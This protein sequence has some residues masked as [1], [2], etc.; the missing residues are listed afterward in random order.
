ML[1]PPQKRLYDLGYYERNRA[2]ILARKRERHLTD[3]RKSMLNG[4]R[5]RAR[6]LG[7]PFDLTEQDLSVPERCPVL[8]IPIFVRGGEG[9]QDHSP[10][11]DRVMPELGYVRG[12][13][14]VISQRANRIKNDASP[15]E[16]EAVAS[17][18]RDT[19]CHGV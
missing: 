2:A 5:K 18:L 1:R 8:G 7:L 17:W 14:V 3:P 11:L 16:L 12:N 13:V 6:Q 15:D 19:L 9:P 10:S 4:A